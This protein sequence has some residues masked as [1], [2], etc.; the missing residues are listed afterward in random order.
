MNKQIL[1]VDDEVQILALLSILFRRSGFD[2]LKA[3]NAIAALS[4]LESTT[5]DLMIV[6]VMMPGMDGIEFC[7]HIRS[8]PE[9]SDTPVVLF[10]ARFDTRTVRR[11]FEAGANEYITKLTPHTELLARVRTMLGLNGARPRERQRVG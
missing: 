2:V 10:S 6:D 4:V 7:K 11:G 9:T 5:P 8:R 3:E 1:I